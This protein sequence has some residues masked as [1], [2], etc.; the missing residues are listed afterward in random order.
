LMLAR[1]TEYVETRRAYQRHVQDFSPD[2]FY[3]I[4]RQAGQYVGEMSLAEILA[5]LRFSYY[6]SAQFTR[7]VPRLTELVPELSRDERQS[8][9]D[10]ID[11]VWD[12]YFPL[13]EE[14]DLAFQIG[15]L[16][17]EMGDY[18]RALT[19]YER[20]IDIYG[21]HTGTLYNMA[22]CHQLIGQFAETE[23]LLHKVLQCD[24]DN[25]QARALLTG[26]KMPGM[27]SPKA[28]CPGR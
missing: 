2:D 23:S 15:G 1:A 6:D 27:K 25:Q 3:T 16:L 9:L 24:P 5:Y 12:L 20:S 11:K 4:T 21:Q 7:Y 8:V 13:G 28:V 26:D 22:A 17:Y 19:F 10:A 18:A 14:P